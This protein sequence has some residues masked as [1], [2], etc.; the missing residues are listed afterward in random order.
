MRER[1][2]DGQRRQPINPRG[3]GNTETAK[4]GWEHKKGE[5]PLFLGFQVGAST[6]LASAPP[7]ARS[8]CVEPHTPRAVWGAR[9]ASVRMPMGL[10]YQDGVCPDS[11]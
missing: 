9:M 3:K 11:R 6:C 5:F 10:G 2:T 4:K 8:V 7:G 1:Q